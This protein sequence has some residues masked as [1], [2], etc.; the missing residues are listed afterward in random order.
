MESEYTIESKRD[1][2]AYSELWHT[3]NVLYEKALE[4]EVGRTHI[5]RAALVF[6]AFA[7]ESFLLHVGSRFFPE[8]KDYPWKSIKDKILHINAKYSIGVDL[9]IRPFQTITILFDKRDLLAHS[10]DDVLLKNYQTKYGLKADK[11]YNRELKHDIE[12][13]CTLD[14]MERAKEDSE[15]CCE[16]IAEKVG[17]DR[18]EL[19]RMGF[20]QGSE[21]VKV[22][23]DPL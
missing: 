7:F 21:S 14:N 19:F 2:I 6:R 23:V 15:K 12:N 16:I 18:S 17:I 22:K 20:R 13:Y 5:I 11:F 1:F 10:K 8:D 4:I 9:G 3:A